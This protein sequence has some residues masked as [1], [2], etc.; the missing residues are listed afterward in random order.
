MM[1]GVMMK[2]IYVVLSTTQDECSCSNR[3]FLDYEKAY[4]YVRK[5][6]KENGCEYNII[7]VELEDEE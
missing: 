6:E 2:K 7:G 5:T 1:R 4:Q 3:A